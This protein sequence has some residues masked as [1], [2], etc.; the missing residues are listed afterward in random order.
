ML[1]CGI[2]CAGWLGAPP[3]Y[4]EA[5]ASEYEVKAA[6]L[7]KLTLFVEWPAGKLPKV[8]EPFLIGVLGKDPFRSVLDETVAGKSVKG[9]PIRV[10][11]S[12]KPEDLVDC[13]IVFISSS[14]K[15]RLTEILELFRE[16]QVLS[17]GDMEGFAEHGGI[18]N[19]R[20]R[21]NKIKF[22]INQE[23]ATR[24]R[25]DLSSKLLRLARIVS[26]TDDV[27]S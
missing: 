3:V 22:D 1:A 10:K 5:V 26:S 24:A 27:E 17:I 21:D 13:H 6:L 25:L 2:V 9:R 15:S 12:Q 7:Y 11:R 16:S 19:L 14:E 8:R 18:I 23:A 4:A 20:M